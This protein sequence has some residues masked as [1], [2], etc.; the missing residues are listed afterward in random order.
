MFLSMK[1]LLC[2]CAYWG[3]AAVSWLFLRQRSSAAG[4]NEPLIFHSEEVVLFLCHEGFYFGLSLQ[5]SQ[6]L[7]WQIGMIIDL[8]MFCSFLL[9]KWHLLPL[10]KGGRPW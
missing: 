9:C 3:S 2:F 6:L 1:T 7:L 4:F 8:I 10:V 5:T